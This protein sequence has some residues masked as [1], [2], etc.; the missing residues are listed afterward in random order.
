MKR[1]RWGLFYM[2]IL[3]DVHFSECVVRGRCAV[4]EIERGKLQI[5]HVREFSYSVHQGAAFLGFMTF[6]PCDAFTAAPCHHGN[7]K[8]EAAQ[9][10]NKIYAIEKR[11][12]EMN[13]RRFKRVSV[14]LALPLML[15]TLALPLTAEAAELAGVSKI[16]QVMVFPAGAEVSREFTLSVPAGEHEIVL[17]DLPQDLMGQSLRIEGAGPEGLTIGSI[18]HKVITLSSED[19][20]VSAQRKQLKDRLQA[21][22]DERDLLEAQIEA[23]Q[24]QVKLL[25]EMTMLPSR[26]PGRDAAGEADLSSQYSALYSMMGEKL[27]EAQ[28]NALQARVKIRALDEDIRIVNDQLGEQPSGVRRVSRL[29]VHVSAEAAGEASFKVKYQ[30]NNAGWRPQYDARLDTEKSSLQLVR[31]AVIYQRSAEDW[32]DVAISLSTTNPT[33]RTSAPE[34]HPWMVDYQQ[35]E[36]N[37][38][39][40]G[41]LS[42]HDMAVPEE[43]P[44]AE[45]FK[46]RMMAKVAKA[47]APAMVRE[48]RVNFGQ[49]QMTFE[50]PGRASILRDG[51]EKKLLLD[52]LEAAPKISLLAVPKKDRK[53]YLLAAFTNETEN[54]LI[55]GQLSLFRDG[56]YVGSTRLNSV[57]PGQEAKLGFGVD[58][59]VSVKWAKLDRVKGKTG[60]ITS[61]NSD[62]H[63]YKIT[64][65]NGHSKALPITVLDQMPY[66]QEETLEIALLDTSPKPSRTDVDDKR[67]VLAW[68]FE[69]GAGKSREI[70]F[71]YQLT[72]PKDKRITLR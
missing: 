26:Q 5:C 36:E 25:N 57:E 52:K 27:L 1:P 63:R 61:S 24:L 15:A 38:R 55:S 22:S 56:V 8:R 33:G 12:I 67:G 69:L 34:L 40:G 53:A 17:T 71:G 21:L 29:V 45:R 16:S 19:G 60:L 18:D 58:P 35:D 43:A 31:R 51:V 50:V 44:Q 23:F 65:A 9:Q 11:K 72:W 10:T 3:S 64:I 70:T 14:T 46:G 32:A 68:D 30:V 2:V 49:Y 4:S 37:D 59:K 13:N 66:A 39:A 48:A 47:P 62:V 42:M 20:L 54:A 7:G 28:T 6:T 41:L